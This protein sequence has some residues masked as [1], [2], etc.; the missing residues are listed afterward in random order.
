VN[1]QGQSLRDRYGEECLS[2]RRWTE[3]GFALKDKAKI[4]GMSK[5][6]S[7]PTPIYRQS[8]VEFVGARKQTAVYGPNWTSVVAPMPSKFGLSAY[9]GDIQ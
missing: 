2:L 6:G 5:Y 7:P 8:D 4:V 9:T 3:L 1:G